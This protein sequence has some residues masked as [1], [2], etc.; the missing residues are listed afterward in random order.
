MIMPVKLI[1]E[2][3]KIDD[4]E[5]TETGIKRLEDKINAFIDQN[6]IDNPRISISQ[7]YS[8]V[9]GVASQVTVT[10]TY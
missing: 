9:A 7:A 1:H 5:K 2:H 8:A 6:K 4:E 10:I 3:I